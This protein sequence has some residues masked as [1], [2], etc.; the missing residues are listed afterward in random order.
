MNPLDEAVTIVE[1]GIAWPAQ[2]A[3]E[4]ARILAALPG[5]RL[6]HIGSTA[7]PGLPAKPVIDLMLGLAAYPPDAALVD[8]IAALGYRNLGEAGVPGR[9]YFVMRGAIDVNL[10][11]VEHAGAHWSNNLALREHLRRS[12]DARRRYAAAKEQALAGGAGTLIA[13]SAA[14]AATIAA[15]L[16]EAQEEPDREMPA[17]E[18]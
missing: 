5:E 18:S 12:A 15:L 10:H 16:Q 4:R 8:A 2:A 17:N 13:Y 1:P 7:V 9:L 14:K 11:A 3:A 6:E